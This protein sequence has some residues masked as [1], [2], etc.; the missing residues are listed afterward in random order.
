[1]EN[2]KNCQKQLLENSE[3]IQFMRVSIDREF[4]LIDRMYFLID[5]RGIE[6]QSSQVETL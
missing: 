1:M 2:S 3:K 6:N 4:L 5:L